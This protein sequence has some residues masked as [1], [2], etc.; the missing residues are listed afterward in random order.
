MTEMTVVVVVP[1]FCVEGKS[2][3]FSSCLSLDFRYL[4]GF[5]KQYASLGYSLSELTSHSSRE[6][7]RRMLIR[8]S[9]VVPGEKDKDKVGLM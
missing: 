9:T 4:T 7:R 1:T 6:G 3:R 8:A 5:L 2:H